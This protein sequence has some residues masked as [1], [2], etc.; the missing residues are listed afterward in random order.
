MVN[1]SFKMPDPQKITEGKYNINQAKGLA[2]VGY[3]VTNIL[4][5]FQSPENDNKEK[6]ME[7]RRKLP[8]TIFPMNELNRATVT[9]AGL[10][11]YQLEK[12]KA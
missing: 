1:V 9:V 3:I 6:H 11:P 12:L 7:I 8:N 10:K 2:S 4:K 5:N